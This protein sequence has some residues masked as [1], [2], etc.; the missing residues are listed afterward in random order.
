MFA[1]IKVHQLLHGYRSGHGLLSGSTKLGS[2]DSELVTRLSDLSGSLSSG[3][4]IE[5]YLSCYPLPSGQ[6]YAVA[7]TWLDTEAPRAGCVLTHTILIPKL[8]WASLKNVRTIDRY[9]RN[10]RLDFDHAFT[11]P[12]EIDSD[13]G[14]TPGTDDGKMNLDSTRTFVSRYFGRGVRPIVWFNA[15]KPE[16][17]LW[18][19]VEHLWPQL[20]GAF[21]CCTCSLQ[22][23]QLQERPFDLLFAPSAVYSRF[24][25]LSSDHILEEGKIQRPADADTEAWCS[26]WAQDLFSAHT[27]LPSGEDELPIW[28]QLGED[29]A[30]LRKLSLI[31]ELRLRAASSP[32]AGVGA[33]DVVESLARDAQ[34]GTPLKV[35][36]FNSAIQ[37]A[38][39]A[40]VVEEGLTALRLIEDRLRREAFKTLSFGLRGAVETASS[41]LAAREPA[42]GIKVLESLSNVSQ[43]T[44]EFQ[45]GILHGLCGAVQ[46]D[47]SVVR[48]LEKYPSTAIRLLNLE[49]SLAAAYLQSAGPAAPNQIVS[50][51]ASTKD[52]DVL[53]TV[54]KAIL[55]TLKGSESEEVI[56]A[57]LRDLASTEV[58]WTLDHLFRKVCNFTST[59]FLKILVDRISS[60]YPAEVR[61]WGTQAK[62]R[63]HPAAA[64]LLATTF[65][66][67]PAG[68]EEFLSE[69]RFSRGQKAQILAEML[70]LHA[71]PGMP[72][73]LREVLAKN[74]EFVDILFSARS[75]AP[76]FFDAVLF[77]VLEEVKDVRLPESAAAHLG[78]FAES[79]IYSLL[80]DNIMRGSLVE[81]LI[82]G[83]R[84]WAGTD[85]VNIEAGNRWL[86]DIPSGELSFLLTRGAAAGAEGVWRVWTWVAE[87][88]RSL[89][90]RRDGA[91]AAIVESL[92]PQL[93]QYSDERTEAAFATV[94]KRMKADGPSEPFQTAAAKSLR[95]AFD[96][97]HLAL[98]AVVAESFPDVYRVAASDRRQ[99]S[100][101]SL[102]FWS[103]D[104]DKG[105][106]LRIA[107][108]DSFLRSSW[109][110]GYLALASERA[111]ILAKIFK[112]VRRNS[113]ANDYIA[114]I[115]KDL[116]ERTS[117]EWS[118]VR[119]RFLSMMADPDF[120]EEWD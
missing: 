94:V 5:S 18:R 37:S 15:P 85:P 8:D 73:W 2:R 29:P 99:P 30:D 89:Y 45:N 36:I 25:K 33:I 11:E 57:V 107:L 81:S 66:D 71:R 4:E 24:T 7:R 59:S 21:S 23:R 119:E 68:Y 31:H 80:V 58:S 63:E 67:G 49:P 112:R 108:V 69:E 106:E 53:R 92:L 114:A 96:N 61:L 62:Q 100:F 39:R 48:E 1:K 82:S 74:N 98:G 103:Y 75:S 42:T 104:W 97:T 116:Q 16:Q 13:E 117:P 44:S 76:E 51:L 95:F 86:C 101:L 87:A 105:K 19:L 72:Y 10:P 55:P 38:S 52:V 40:N 46:R 26:L 12:F 93:R 110:P 111:G 77:R 34:S 109:K 32:T 20:R 120:Y 56:A 6:F 9:F 54:R 14:Y 43:D 113:R 60:V 79:P 84:N 50:W 78:D 91:V 70:E 88:P 115:V 3:L 83:N 17:Y 22:P 35:S 65:Q 41:Q 90:Q 28:N 102:L 118:K 64:R 47:D 27:G